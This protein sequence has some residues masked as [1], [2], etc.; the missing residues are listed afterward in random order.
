M[1]FQK[2]IL[3]TLIVLSLPVMSAPETPSAPA[4]PATAPAASTGT[5]SEKDF[6]SLGGNREL[7]D[8]ARAINP[9]MTTTIVQQRMVERRNRVELSPEVGNVFGGN[10]YLKSTSVGLNANFH[11]TP[12]WSIG[13]RYSYYFNEL[14]PEGKEAYDNANSDFN[15][16]PDNP[17]VPFP[18]VDYPKSEMMGLINWY[19]IYGKMNLIDKMVAHFDVYLVGGYGQIELSSGGTGT[20]TAG[21]GMGVWWTPHLSSRLEA[22]YQTYDTKSLAS[23]RSI[24]QTIGTL[25]MGWLL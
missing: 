1:K 22:R 16:N 8:K 9:Q 17:R 25:Q 15:K 7:L 10:S 18:Q 24:D 20:W 21:A 3:A 12:R 6:D 2:L 11:F 23:S 14:T 19:P 5:M 13:A 4:K